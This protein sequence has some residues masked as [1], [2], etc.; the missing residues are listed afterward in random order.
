MSYLFRDYAT[1]E[2]ALPIELRCDPNA[3]HTYPVKVAVKFEFLTHL[4]LKVHVHHGGSKEEYLGGLFEVLED[5]YHPVY[6]G[7]AMRRL[8]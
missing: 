8:D 1:L 2:R 3:R 5:L 6:H 7:Q 4:G